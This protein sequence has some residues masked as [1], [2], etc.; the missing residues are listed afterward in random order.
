VDAP[1]PGL[2]RLRRGALRRRR[3]D[4]P[5]LTRVARAAITVLLFASVLHAAPAAAGTPDDS[6][7]IDSVGAALPGPQ[8]ARADYDRGFSND[9]WAG[10]RW[11]YVWVAW[12]DI[13]RAPGVYDFAGLDGLVASAHA[14]RVHLM[15][16]VQTAGDFVLPGPAQ[17]ANTGGYRTNSRHP[18][19]PSSAPRDMSGPMEFWRALARHYMPD[20]DLARARGWSDGYGVRFFEVEN[21]P[22][23]FPW[24]TG[25]WSTVPKDYALYVSIV[26]QTLESLSPLLRV[27]GPAIATGPDSSGCCN[28]LSWLEQVLRA[29]TGLDWASDDYRAAVAAGRKVL[30]AGPF[31]D[32][33]S[34]HDDFYQAASSYSQERARAVRA[35]V[36]RY[37]RESDPV[38]W[39][40][41]G[42]PLVRPGDQV[43]Y[44]RTQAQ[45]TIRLLHAGVGRLNFDTGM[46]GDS[47]SALAS[48]PAALEA[49]AMAT[50]FPSATGIRDES[51]R[52]G[53]LAGRPVEAYSWT[54]PRTR[55][56]SLIVWAPDEAAGSGA[57]GPAFDVRL[58]VKTARAVVVDRDWS[59]HETTATD[60]AVA[61]TLQ[62]ADPSGVVI[63]AERP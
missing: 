3:H 52:I 13:E 41:E 19:P 30:S 46:R 40:T 23:S 53:S 50:Y 18:M 9:E 60:G 61:V 32:A 39:M 20:G 33:F 55:L 48:D 5:P 28:G 12:S 35:L 54:N 2:R 26:K 27:V 59:T 14:H 42:A 49:R 63:V 6:P 51:A 22:D 38:V 7:Y 1:R 16:Q 58:P 25:T 56:T 11:A 57:T 62:P 15:M 21:E 17:L 31:I 24:I 37:A 43:P 36:G 34:F 8:W 4:P 47:P 29:D 10:I 45:V 44:A